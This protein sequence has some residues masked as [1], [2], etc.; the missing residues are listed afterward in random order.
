MNNQSRT[1]S[2]VGYITMIGW[3][4]ALIMRL[5]EKPQSELSRFHLRQ[6]LGINLIGLALSAIQ[7]ILSILYLSFIGNILGVIFFILWLL[8]LMAAIQGQFRR[9]PFVGQ[10]FEENFDF[11]R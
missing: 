2:I 3:V 6:S 5:S 8:G 10:W 4:I 7:F 9:I 11:V 1:I